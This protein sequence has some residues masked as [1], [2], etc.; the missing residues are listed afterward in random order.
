M[1][2]LIYGPQGCGRYLKIDVIADFLGMKDFNVIREVYFEMTL[3]ENTIAFTC[4]EN[5]K[6]AINFFELMAKIALTQENKLLAS[7]GRE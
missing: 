5:I 4:F 7:V 3:P 2:I 6:G 1:S